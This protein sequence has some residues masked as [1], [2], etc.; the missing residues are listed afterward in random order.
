VVNLIWRQ[1]HP[2]CMGSDM[3]FMEIPIY[4]LCRSISKNTSN[5]DLIRYFEAL[6]KG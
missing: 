1:K 3:N 2:T 4:A 6:A 5:L